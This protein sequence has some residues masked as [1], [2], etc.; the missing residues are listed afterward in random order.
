M[1]GTMWFVAALLASQSA[2]LD[3]T[4]VA[5][6][7]PLLFRRFVGD[8]EPG[9]TALLAY[10]PLWSDS[11]STLVRVVGRSGEAVVLVPS[12]F[13]AEASRW[14]KRLGSIRQRVRLLS[15]PLDSP[16][17]RDFG[18]LAVETSEGQTVWLDARYRTDRSDDDM[19]PERLSRHFD[20]RVENLR[21]ELEG[22]AIVGDGH[23]LCVTTE[24]SW[25]DTGASAFTQGG[26]D[27]LLHQLGCASLALVPS[28]LHD[29]TQHVDM[30][31]QFIGPGV[32]LV[33]QVDPSDSFEDYRRIE[34]AIQSMRRA[35]AVLGKK[36][37]VVRV[38]LPVHD[39]RHYR[40]YVNGLRLD[41]VF[42]APSYAD[43]DRRTEEEAH[44][45]LRR[46]M[47]DVEIILVPALDM[48]RLDGAVHCITT[49]LRGGVSGEDLALARREVDGRA[50]PARRMTRW[51]SAT[52][53]AC[54]ALG[55]CPAAW[56][57]DG[58]TM[59]PGSATSS[60]NVR[61]SR[62]R[63]AIP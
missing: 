40:T 24:S 38:R 27:T 50:E 60:R 18:P 51:L 21:V 46:A 61:S 39:R 8:W 44:A 36:L 1:H 37:E 35:A 14:W 12:K 4:V 16:W 10:E 2:P 56:S 57:M 43:V 62:V 49:V 47:P 54:R 30:F 31:V 22:G 48:I 42:F 52:S 34:T 11:L 6:S 15:M 32:A 59:V 3:A 17:V 63:P 58:Q 28:L 19:V 13:E 33:G 55:D 29:P 7:N 25:A 41:G 45:Q 53:A 20:V 9:G 23:G 5:P 26:L